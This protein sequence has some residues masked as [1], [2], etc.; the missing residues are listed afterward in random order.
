MHSA[1]GIESVVCALVAAAVNAVW[2]LPLM[3]GA[4]WLVSRM[5]RRAGAPAQHRVWVATLGLCVL[6]PVLPLLRTLAATLYG[7]QRDV[8]TGAGRAAAS[9]GGPINETGVVAFPEFVLWAVFALY[10]ASLCFFAARLLR[11]LWWT[12]GLMR[13]S[14]AW[15]CDG[16][17]LA[18]W[19]RAKQ[20]FGVQGAELRVARGITSPVAVGSVV[21]VPEGW[22][23]NCAPE[24]LLAALGHE[25][26]HVKRQDFAK[27]VL[28]EF[29]TL[30]IAFHPVTWLLKEGVA[31]TRELVCD[32]LA[33]ERLTG[34]ESY[35]R[36]LLRLAEMVLAAPRFNK[37]QAIGI[38]DADVLEERVMQMTVKQQ[39]LGRG[40][41]FA[42]VAMAAGLLLGTAGGGAAMAF[43]VTTPDEAGV[44]H[45]GGDVISPKIVYATDPRYT[46]AARKKKLQGVCVVSLLVDTTGVPRDVRV[47]KSL[48]PGLDANAV[49]AVRG[50][51]FK[52]GMRKGKPVTTELNIEVNF[53]LF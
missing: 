43:G 53:Q 39:R 14:S 12:R 46:A 48:D 36:S 42:G 40:R 20:A 52:P 30:P 33:A 21:L 41:V 8:A 16:P 11:S 24:D 4:G 29:A 28:Y 27:N 44:F 26:A 35:V 5:L 23:A 34:T 15:I 6:T 7:P 37:T 17:E 13:S 19:E 1:S 31:G 47:V 10:L 18:A 45:P 38:F 9:V 22:S 50:Y 3:G 49:K 2:E 51:R 25:C 32:R